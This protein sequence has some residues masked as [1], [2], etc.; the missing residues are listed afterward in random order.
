MNFV[1]N[2]QATGDVANVL[3]SNNF[4][5]GAL[6]PYIGADGRSYI[7]VNSGR[8]DDKGQPIM[9][10]LVTNAP[11]TLRKDEWI[12]FDQAV[13]KAA[14]PRLRVVADMRAAGLQ[15][16][17]PNGLGK[18]QLEH[19]AQS[20][21][22]DASI[23]MDGLRE[24]NSDR[25]LYDLRS[26]PLPILHK[27]FQFSARQVAASRNGG[28][29][30]D[31]TNAELAGRKVAEMAEK[32]ALGEAGGYAFGGGNVYGLTNFPSRLT[33]S[34]TQPTTSNQKVTVNEVLAMIQQSQDNNY[35]GPWMLYYSPAWSIFMGGD[36]SDNKGDN[37][38]K[39]RIA[40]IDGITD[41]RQA[42]YLSGTQLVL[43]Q[44][45]ADVA[46]TVVGMD[47]TT[48]QWQSHGGMQ[49]NF[50][51]MAII[52]PQLRGDYNNQTGIVH[53]TV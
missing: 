43:V 53:G 2:G 45:T 30:L 7:T 36:Y 11:A 26:L 4:D 51:V 8:V 29:P 31:T 13:I 24:G 9:N 23:S 3:M 42:D 47:I 40:K 21:I 35:Y 48:L 46:R 15:Y 49:L 50:K 19:E 37:L 28:S 38:L 52:V 14:K 12:Q 39:D 16:N 1:L 41:V 25:P 18:M 27:D 17:I 34:L 5:A 10:S 44:Q 32:L 33:K 6:R 22:G 20:D